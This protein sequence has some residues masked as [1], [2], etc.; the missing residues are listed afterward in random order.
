MSFQEYVVDRVQA[1][2]AAIE[3]ESGWNAIF[4]NS[5]FLF[6]DMVVNRKTIVDFLQSDDLRRQKI[7]Q[8]SSMTVE[9]YDD[10]TVQAGFEQIRRKLNTLSQVLQSRPI[11]GWTALEILDHVE[12]IRD[13]DLMQ[14]TEFPEDI[15]GKI[16]KEAISRK[17]ASIKRIA[18]SQAQR[19]P[20]LV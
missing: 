16:S 4:E 11:N 15:A 10:A 1:I 6:D 9:R 20:G 17:A 8:A 2:E 14:G 13:C 5:P 19:K 12:A 3:G 7:V 18:F